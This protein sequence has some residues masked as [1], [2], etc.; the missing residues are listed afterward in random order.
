[1]AAGSR[2][3]HFARSRKADGKACHPAAAPLVRKEA[4]EVF[5]GGRARERWRGERNGRKRSGKKGS[6]A[7]RRM[8]GRRRCGRR[9]IDHRPSM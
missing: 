2:Q 7:G 9:I 4:V 1:M 6:A 3:Q 8:E 5:G